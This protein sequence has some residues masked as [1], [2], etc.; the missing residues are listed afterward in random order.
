MIAMRKKDLLTQ[1]LRIDLPR[2]ILRIESYKILPRKII[3]STTLPKF[4]KPIIPKHGIRPLTSDHPNTPNKKRKPVLK[5]PFT[6]PEKSQISRQSSKIYTPKHSS[7][8]YLKRNLR[9]MTFIS[10]RVLDKEGLVLR[11]W[12]LRSKVGLFLP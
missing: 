2:Q 5:Y 4:R 12:L 6:V 11:I 1:I 9:S 3:S 8:P 7:P 10:A